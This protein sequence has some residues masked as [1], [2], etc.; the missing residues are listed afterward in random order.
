MVM[1]EYPEQVD[2]AWLA[3]DSV[4]HV[5]VFITAG[6]GPIPETV[7]KSETPIV[8]IESKLL[9]LPPMAPAS[10]AVEVPSPGSFIALAERGLFVF[11]WQ[12][13]HRTRAELKPGYDL[14]AIPTRPIEI[15]AMPPDLASIAMNTALAKNS[16]SQEKVV[17]VGSALP[18]SMKMP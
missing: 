3:V 8:E 17:D 10:L 16:F 5:A 13:V 12:N 15:T 2:C 7:L 14:V 6:V 1:Q 11:D 9:E 4:G 18:C